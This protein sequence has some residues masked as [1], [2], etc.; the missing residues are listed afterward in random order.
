MW[1]QELSTLADGL[2][3]LPARPAPKT[4][5]LSGFE[6]QQRS[7]TLQ[8]QRHRSVVVRDEPAAVD[9]PK[10]ARRANPETAPV[11]VLQR[12]A[13]PIEGV[14]ECHVTV[15]GDREAANLIPERT[16]ECCED[17]YPVIPFCLCSYVLQRRLDVE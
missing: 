11:S 4:A 9:L 5:K 17:L 7:A 10:A 13:E 12:A 16:L 6:I 3:D 1:R 14:R 15:R 8:I 2:C